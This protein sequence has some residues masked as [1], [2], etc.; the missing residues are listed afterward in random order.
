MWMFQCRM[1]LLGVYFL[2]FVGGGWYGQECYTLLPQQLIISNK[3]NT[4]STVNAID[5]I[6]IN[7]KQFAT[8]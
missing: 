3:I 1:R 5:Y 2:D 4:N 8:N 6:N 7:V